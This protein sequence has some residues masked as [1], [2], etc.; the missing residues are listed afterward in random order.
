M[1]EY[2]TTLT[3]KQVN[4]L[5][6][7][8][9]QKGFQIS[10]NMLSYLYALARQGRRYARDAQQ[11]DFRKRIISSLG[12]LFEAREA[13]RLYD[14]TS[15]EEERSELY[16]RIQEMYRRETVEIRKAFEILCTQSTS[17]YLVKI[18]RELE[19]GGEPAEAENKKM[20]S[21]QCAEGLESEET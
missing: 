4:M 18:K 6:R 8:K 15:N 11:E 7:L 13:E 3:K 16:S 1:A 5:W 10:E 17:R 19:A 12:R 14:E 20:P 21:A 9:A 2:Y